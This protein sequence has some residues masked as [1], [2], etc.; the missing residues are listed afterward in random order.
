[1]WLTSVSAYSNEAGLHWGAGGDIPVNK[2]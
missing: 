1:M 2:R